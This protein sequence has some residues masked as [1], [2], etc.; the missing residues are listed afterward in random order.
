MSAARFARTE[1]APR[2]AAMV[3][4]GIG[5]LRYNYRVASTGVAIGI[6]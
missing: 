5:F 1:M 3:D 6:S 4:R 2:T